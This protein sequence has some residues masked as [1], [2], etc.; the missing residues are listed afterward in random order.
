MDQ[1][2]NNTQTNKKKIH[3][4]I[5]YNNYHKQAIKIKH[6]EKVI[7]FSKASGTKVITKI[8]SF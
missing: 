6:T 1:P 2:I 5:T 7:F 4:P 8:Q 3:R